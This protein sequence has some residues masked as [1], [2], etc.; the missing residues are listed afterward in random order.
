MDKEKLYVVS[1]CSTN[2]TGNS[3]LSFYA[4]EDDNYTEGRLLST[5]KNGMVICA[6]AFMAGKRIPSGGFSIG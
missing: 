3:A 1:I 2:A 4:S 6:L 5:E